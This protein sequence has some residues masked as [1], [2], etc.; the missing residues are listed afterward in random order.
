MAGEQYVPNL[1][2]L[3]NY[4]TAGWGSLRYGVG[5]PSS[6]LGN[7]GDAYVDTSTGNFYD[8]TESG[9]QL[10]TGGVGVQQV[11]NGSAENPNTQSIFPDD[12]SLPAIYFQ[13]GSEVSNEWRWD[14]GEQQWF[15]VQSGGGSGAGSLVGSVDPEG[16]VSA[17]AGTIYTN[18]SQHTLWAKESGSG[19]VGWL[20]YV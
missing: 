2:D 13:E 3:P 15:L 12:L 1:P 17:P 19:S 20:Q 18:S 14:V 9:W 7:V 6:T 10:V 16:A 4:G 11:L 5:A 8:K